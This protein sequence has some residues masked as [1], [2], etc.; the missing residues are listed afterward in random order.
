[1]IKNKYYYPTDRYFTINVHPNYSDRGSTIPNG[2]S[3]YLK[4]SN[5]SLSATPASGYNFIKWNDENTNASRTVIVTS[6]KEYVAIF[7]QPTYTVTYNANGAT[8]GSA[9]IDSDSPYTSGHSVK[10]LGNTG[11]LTKTG[12]M[13][14]GWNTLANGSGTSYNSG[15]QF[16][17]SGD[18]TLYAQWVSENSVITIYLP[19]NDSGIAQMGYMYSGNP[20]DPKGDLLSKKGQFSI[21]CID[22]NGSPWGEPRIH[23]S[24][25]KPNGD[26]KRGTLCTFAVYEG[27]LQ[28]EYSLR[29][30][31]VSIDYIDNGHLL[32]MQGTRVYD[33]PGTEPY[34]GVTCQYYE[35]TLPITPTP[36]SI[37]I[38]PIWESTVS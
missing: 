14:S 1:M 16:T 32:E 28:S 26:R 22:N 27:N 20:A 8:S 13:F 12:Y 33:M 18:I 37:T 17:I 21:C 35:F 2:S 9:P 24:G 31:G 38:S 25:S 29:L 34:Y 5:L 7:A 36:S 30:K 3:L 10:V 15:D 11:G 4:G 19:K 6:D 23:P